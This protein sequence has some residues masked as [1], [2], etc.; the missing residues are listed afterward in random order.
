MSDYSGTPLAEKLGIASDSAVALLGAPEGFE[1]TLEPLP[2]GVVVQTAS[3]GNLD[4]AVLFVRR[5]S[6]L[7]RRFPLVARHLTPAGGLWVGWPQKSSGVDTDLDFGVVQSVGLDTGLVDNK[8]CALD[9][10][11]SG[12]RFVVRREDREGWPGSVLD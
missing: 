12:L 6:R 5:E 2:D 1:A 7:R 3:R 4:V 10:T 9:D 11:Y 8:R